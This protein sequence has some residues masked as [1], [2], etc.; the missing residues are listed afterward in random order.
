[1]KAITP[2]LRLTLALLAASFAVA[3]AHATDAFIPVAVLDF[4]SRNDALSDAGQ[5][6]AATISVRLSNE[7]GIATVERTE[8]GKIF[9]EQELGLAGDVDPTSM[10]HLGQ[11]TGAKILVTGRVFRSAGGVSVVVKVIGTETGRVYGESADIPS[12]DSLAEVATSLATK[13]AAT[14]KDHR[15]A[16]IAK[17]LP[18]EERIQ[19]LKQAVAGKH[20]PRVA[21]AIS[22]RHFG[23]PVIDPAAQTEFTLILQQCG[24]TVVDSASAIAPDVRISGD[25]F[26]AYGARR[27][28]VVSCTA[29]LELKIQRLGSD[30]IMVD[31][32]TSVAL[33]L[34][35]QSA[36]KSA[37]ESA[38]AIAAERIVP[39][40][41]N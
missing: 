4:E 5:R 39:K 7:P 12:T 18:L 24:F 19:Q 9:G 40:L 20:L 25:A 22:E 31:R 41:V 3:L 17:V 14:I 2:P 28:N 6:I 21:V 10:V 1:M 15:D 23:N 26:S 11:L 13:I 37:L 30:A 32:Q 36:A 38:A 8:L 33:D 27:G 29:R 16:L 35:E 34:A